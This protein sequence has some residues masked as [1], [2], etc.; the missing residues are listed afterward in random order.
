M[1]DQMGVSVCCHTSIARMDQPGHE[2]IEKDEAV[3][4][5]GADPGMERPIAPGDV[6]AMGIEMGIFLES[7]A[8]R[9]AFAGRGE[10]NPHAPIPRGQRWEERRGGKEW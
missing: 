6:R 7:L 8:F 2:T 5:P 4:A 1:G 3:V 10:M 9:P